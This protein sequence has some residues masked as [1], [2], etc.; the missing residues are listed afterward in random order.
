LR[1]EIGKRRQDSTLAQAVFVHDRG[2]FV[3]NREERLVVDFIR[4]V[5]Q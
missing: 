1:T 5:E 4:S 3:R 2:Y